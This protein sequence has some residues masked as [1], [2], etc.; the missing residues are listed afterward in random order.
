VIAVVQGGHE[1]EAEISRMTSKS[2]QKALIELKLDYK[3]L[4]YDEDFEKN[5]KD[6]DPKVCLLAL[7]GKTAEDGCAQKLLERLGYSYTGSG[8]EASKLAFSKVDSIKKAR[9]M[10]IPTLPHVHVK[11]GERVDQKGIEQISSWPDGFVVKPSESGSSR[12]VSLC[13]SLDELEASLLEAFRWDEQAVV[14]KR[15]KGRELTVSVLEGRAFEPIEIRPKTG[16]YDIKNKYT[17]GATDYLIPAPISE[18]LKDI[19][20]KHAVSIFEGFGLS[21]YARVDYMFLDDE[22]EIYFMEVNTLPG[23]TETSLL[24]KALAYEGVPFTKLI[25]RLLFLANSKS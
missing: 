2:F 8:V 23:C 18:E 22:S 11:K 9:S 12:G 1:S 10:G 25:Q 24:P 3:V 19:S 4:E 20:K 13:S 7:H 5:L 16:F 6:L 21:A 15:V 14:E 17:A